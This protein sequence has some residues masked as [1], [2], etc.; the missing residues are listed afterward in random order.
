MNREGAD[1]L[2]RAV[3]G[4]ER[5]WAMGTSEH[6]RGTHWGTAAASAAAIE[7]EITKGTGVY[8]ATAFVRFSLL[9]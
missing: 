6:E 1:Y 7:L 4:G 3:Q 8:T 9:F 5:S 2:S